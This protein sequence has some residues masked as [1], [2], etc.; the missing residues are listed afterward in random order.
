MWKGE[1]GRGEQV[2]GEQVQSSDYHCDYSCKPYPKPRKWCFH[3]D[4]LLEDSMHQSIGPFQF[5]AQCI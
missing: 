3:S 2:R 4:Q 5:C 1:K